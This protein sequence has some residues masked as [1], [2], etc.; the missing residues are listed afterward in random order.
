MEEGRGGKDF[1]KNYSKQGSH[2]DHSFFR[3]LGWLSLEE[4]SLKW[5]GKWKQMEQKKENELKRE[6]NK[7]RRN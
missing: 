5:S 1:S 2:A 7:R 6:K 4:G 3:D